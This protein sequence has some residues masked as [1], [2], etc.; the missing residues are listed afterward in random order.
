M[1]TEAPLIGNL[2]SF[3]LFV[4]CM[5]V[6]AYA[7]YIRRRPVR[8]PRSLA[9]SDRRS[10][11][12]AVVRGGEQMPVTIRD[13]AEL[14]FSVIVR[15]QNAAGSIADTLR[16]VHEFLAQRE[17]RDESGSYEVIAID[18]GSEDQTFEEMEKFAKDHTEFRAVRLPMPV[19]NGVL[20]TYTGARARGQFIFFFTPGEGV[21]I[22][23]FD[24][25]L[26][27]MLRCYSNGEKVMVVGRYSSDTA[28][29]CAERS[30]LSLLC[31][32][33]TNAILSFNGI[34]EKF[35]DTSSAMMI[36]REAG[37]SMF[38][39]MKLSSNVCC[40]LIT[41]SEANVNVEAV[42]LKTKNMYVNGSV[43]QIITMINALMMTIC[44]YFNLW[45][46]RTISPKNNLVQIQ[47]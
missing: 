34:D 25:F 8:E 36:S 38:L 32:Y 22:E 43:E 1:A 14:R 42:Q 47:P 40:D 16:H 2:L 17:A 33:F 9:K 3:L 12:S 45:S 39:N 24:A 13:S 41:A 37:R 21:Q 19:R 6:F 30:A 23:D 27:A 10:K 7:I 35:R 26:D 29:D 11:Q 20:N 46:I 18:N 44:F 15:A 5:C 31:E 28:G 4:A